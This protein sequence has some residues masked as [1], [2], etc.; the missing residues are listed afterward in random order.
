MR[1]KKDD[2]FEI[3]PHDYVYEITVV[4]SLLGLNTWTIRTFIKKGLVQPKKVG[5]KKCLFCEDDIRKLRKIKQ[6]MEED[7]L[8]LIK[9][10]LD[11]I[12]E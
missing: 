12:E 1:R 7:K 6:L 2:F 4:S 8:E 9:M 11:F 10:V 5:K 3:G